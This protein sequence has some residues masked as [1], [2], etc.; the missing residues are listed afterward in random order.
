M[1]IDT[2]ATAPLSRLTLLSTFCPPPP[3]QTKA[4]KPNGHIS[5]S[6]SIHSAMSIETNDNDEAY[7]RRDTARQSNGNEQPRRNSNHSGAEGELTYEMDGEDGEDEIYARGKG[8]SGLS[9]EESRKAV[10]HSKSFHQDVI[11]GFP[12][13]KDGMPC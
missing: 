2:E 11:S 4:D 13:S 8:I 10:V 1:T 12:S 5:Q 9:A 7:S 6:E 3:P